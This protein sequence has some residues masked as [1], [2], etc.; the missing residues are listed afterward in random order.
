VNVTGVRYSGE[1]G[2]PFHVIDQELVILSLDHPFI[3]VGRFASVLVRD[4]G[5]AQKL[6]SGFDELWTKAKKDLREITFL[7]HL[8]D[9]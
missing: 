6:A 1:L 9:D 2:H 7:P 3:F 4:V 8:E 5:L